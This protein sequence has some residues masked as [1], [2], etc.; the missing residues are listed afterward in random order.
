MYVQAK[1]EISNRAQ[2][3]MKNSKNELCDVGLCFLKIII[4]ESTLQ[5][6]NLS[7]FAQVS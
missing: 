6:A 2:S 1:I 5:G 7:T 3:S 4:S